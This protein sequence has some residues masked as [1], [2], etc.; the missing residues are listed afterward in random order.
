M[1]VPR[2]IVAISCTAV[3]AMSWTLGTMQYDFLAKP[4]PRQ[5]A[6]A[7]E[8]WKGEHLSKQ[9]PAVVYNPAAL[10][11]ITLQ[12]D[13]S[14]KKQN[15]ILLGDLSTPPPLNFYANQKNFGPVA[16]RQLAK[17]LEKLGYQQQALLAYE[18]IL[19]SCDSDK[20]QR[21]K[22]IDAIEAI[23]GEV[24]YINPQGSKPIGL[25]IHVGTPMENSK[26]LKREI[27]HLGQEISL[28]SGQTLSFKSDIIVSPAPPP[29]V[30]THPETGEPLPPP[31]IAMALWLSRDDRF[32]AETPPVAMMMPRDQPELLKQIIKDAVYDS[33]QRQLS[34]NANFIVPAKREQLPAGQAPFDQ[35]TRALWLELGTSLQGREI[36]KVMVVEEDDEEDDE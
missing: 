19:D 22:A 32:D 2:Y 20:K 3:A 13:K 5:L 35:M 21:A 12:N 24:K 29:A 30:L 11:P 36:P 34:T 28:R 9:L 27:E 1:K 16:M 10:A 8:E 6:Q 4:T 33:S 17:R 31:P 14:K 15:Q 26:D 7:A 25:T 23:S 18:R